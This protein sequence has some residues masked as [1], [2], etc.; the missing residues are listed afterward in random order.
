MRL[1]LLT[2]L[3][4]C[5][6][7]AFLGC[8]AEPDEV[9]TAPPRPPPPKKAPVQPLAPCDSKDDPALSAPFTDNF[10][11]TDLG[12]DWRSTSYGAYFLRN[13]KLCIS[14]PRNHPLWLKRKL[15]N[16]VRVEFDAQPTSAS[17][18]IKAEL[19]GDGCAFDNEGRDYTA[20]AY[21]FVLGAHNNSEHWLARMY[22][23]GPEAKKTQLLAGAPSMANAKLITQ[24]VYKIALERSDAKTVSIKVDGTL[25]HEMN[26]PEP[27]GGT[28]HDHF[29][30]NGWDA[31]SCFDN[32]VITPLP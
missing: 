31:P 6:F 17:A 7:P 11:R 24:T 4:P 15:P 27:L 2:V 23:H 28:G 32:L 16:N 25:I 26:D 3:L 22:E 19:F 14:K 18:D 21:V 5:V 10:D 20:T 12:N 13:N 1:R 9:V 29:A 8:K 30:F